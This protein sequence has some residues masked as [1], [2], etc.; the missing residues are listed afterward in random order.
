MNLKNL[1]L[2]IWILLLVS[3][4][5]NAQPA[6]NLRFLANDINDRLPHSDVNTIIQDNFGFLWFGTYNGL[7]RYDG[8][9]LKVFKKELYNPNSLSN[10]RI[11]CLKEL[12]DGSILIGTE[13][14]GLNHYFP[15]S[16]RIRVY[17]KKEDQGPSSDV[18]HTIFE[19]GDGSIWVGTGSGLDLMHAIG[20]SVYFEK[21]FSSANG[22]ME[23]AE[24]PEGTLLFSSGTEVFE[25][26]KEA[27]LYTPKIDLN[28]G[29]T[30]I[31][32]LSKD[33]AIIGCEDGL[34]VIQ[35]G[36]IRTILD[37][38]IIE[39]YQAH[40][41]MI[42]VGT[43]GY[44][45][46]KIDENFQVVNR[47]T[48]NKSDPGSLT[49]NEVSCLFEDHSG[50]LWVG[51]YGRGLNKLDLRAKKFDLY[52]NQPWEKN[53]LSGDRVISFFEDSQKQIWIGLRG[54]GINIL[55]NEN[56]IKTISDKGG[57]PFY[58]Q[59]VSAFYKDP[60]G[61]LWVGSWGGGIV[62]FS[63]EKISTLLNGGNPPAD[64]LL[65][66]FQSVEK[67]VEDYEGHV[68]LSTT[69]DLLQYIP[70]QQDYY[71]GEFRTYSSKD[72]QNPI[73]DS[74]I[75]DLYIEKGHLEGE[76][77]VW[78]GTRNGLNR[79]SLQDNEYSVMQIFSDPSDP[80]SLPGNFVSVITEDHRG[81]LWVSCLDGGI[82][83]MI[84]GRDGK[85][86]VRFKVY[87]QA[88]GLTNNDIETIL[89]DEQ[90][91][92][93][94]GGYGL[95]RFEPETGD[96]VGFDLNDGLQSNSFKV[97]AALK[98]RDGKLVFGGTKGFN[99]FNPGEIKINDIPPKLTFTD[100]KVNNEDIKVSSPT[101]GYKVLDS[102]ILV[103]HHIKLPYK[104]NSFTLS[105]GALHFTSPENNQLKFRLEGVDAEWINVQ[106]PET[107]RNYSQLKPG[108]YIFSFTGAN[109]DN[110]WASAPRSLSI[111]IQKPYWASNYAIA[112]YLVI[113][114]VVLLVFRK[115][116]I[117]QV[118]E[119]TQI[120]LERMRRDQKEELNRLK[121]NFYTEV[122]HELRTPLS[123]I[124][125][126]VSDILE[127]HTLAANDHNKLEIVKRNAERMTNL[128]DEIML[129]TEYGREI[130][131]I[132]A[133]EG[134]IIKFVREIQLFFN[135]E[136]AGR[137]IDFEF[138][139]GVSE[140]M[141]YFD[142]DK[143]EKV[144]FNLLSNAFKFTPEG[145]SVTIS[146]F[147][148]DEK[149]R[150][151]FSIF[152]T[153]EQ[154]PDE[155]I[156]QIFLQFYT[157]KKSNIKGHG[158]GLSVALQII[159]QHHGKIWVE[160]K[161]NGVCFFVELPTGKDHFKP[162]EVIDNFSGTENLSQYLPVDSKGSESKVKVKDKTVL[163][164]EDNVDLREY[165]SKHLSNHFD[166]LAAPDGKS[167][168]DMA[169][170]HIP[171]II[172][173][174][175]MMPVMDGLSMCRKLKTNLLTSHI[176]IIILT[177]RTTLMHQID[178]FEVGADAYVT[179]PF[180]VRLLMA[181][182][183]NLITSREKL[184]QQLRDNVNLSP[185]E[186]T[187]TSLD[188]RI[189]TQTMD[190]IEQYID[191]SEFGVEK[192]CKEIGMSRPQLYRK[193][194]SLTSYS[195]NDFIRLMRL[196]RA[197]QLLGQDNSSVSIVMHQVG[198]ENLS[199]FSKAFKDQFGVSPKQYASK[200]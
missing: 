71:Q 134:D 81:S 169:I 123:L 107:S 56:K 133:A 38:P 161:T 24:D 74:F 153:G 119:M 158:I 83:K 45:L 40:D 182:I 166:I 47:Y 92:F 86:K 18:I 141:I 199:Y 122:S 37:F 20:D 178:G 130:S 159:K 97:W 76:K 79:I 22:V 90:G 162:Q 163:I 175:L 193:I 116:S 59:S 91:W 150:I 200:N 157:R 137:N 1:H 110:I 27:R 21:V 17:N 102:S 188:E 195:I 13:A 28:S 44:G 95:T 82:A 176:P 120:K 77:I 103:T 39:I 167:G 5:T 127:S 57:S 104:L 25:K 61:G 94:M 121:I 181:R 111:T 147:E 191:D 4:I 19:A 171:D 33:Q 164:V 135:A 126:P 15:K 136:A 99:I 64:T 146:A 197:A 124:S 131:R 30:S 144:F 185:K 145:G 7:C 106:G 109:S 143:L 10:S 108:T 65:A 75:R 32:P 186:I 69:T 151:V 189:L 31:M 89:E 9:N 114:V 68:W 125:G 23:V 50:V 60:Q 194:K 16:E 80:M 184:A 101:D 128:V 41:S 173:S 190:I 35:G 96:V 155:D 187:V 165:L 3:Y 87:S 58:G 168:L 196:K 140:Y 14:G 154:I 139:P 49:S 36:N 105:F 170:K 42:W 62:V 93:W 198:F 29:V 78:V 112:L 6:N 152:N 53:S 12:F 26:K 177:A 138:N 156:D 172:I 66:G 85:S 113:T 2:F 55:D 46:L 67:I 52:T 34:H 70:G 180:D 179:K 142:R 48:S 117:I 174:D 8:N 118:K 51:T 100:I 73:T 54:N 84:S 160:N 63:Q 148:K 98:T 88:D 129:F 132:K 149:K 11:L 183:S 115:Y 72:I 192:L 43:R